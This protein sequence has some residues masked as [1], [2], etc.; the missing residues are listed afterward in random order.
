M[1]Q[2]R[3]AKRT[4]RQNRVKIDAQLV[5][6]GGCGC[7]LGCAVRSGE[8]GTRDENLSDYAGRITARDVQYLSEGA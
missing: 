4:T 8:R 5:E 1:C 3:H 6:S 7:I 2:I